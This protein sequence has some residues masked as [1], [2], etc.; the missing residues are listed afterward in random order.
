MMSERA[1]YD[2]LA[3]MERERKRD[4]E[5]RRKKGEEVDEAAEAAEDFLGVK[6]LVEKLERRKAKEANV[7]DD[8][9]W[10]PTDSDSDEDD[11]RFSPDSISRRV[12]EFDRKCKRHS[13][14]LRSFAEAGKNN[15]ISLFPFFISTTFR[16]DLSVLLSLTTSAMQDHISGIDRIAVADSSVF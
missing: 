8:F 1:V 14:L 3:E 15:N 9:F 5:E 6:P 11:E 12:G 13:E 2:L 10:E 7:A 16:S 4:Q